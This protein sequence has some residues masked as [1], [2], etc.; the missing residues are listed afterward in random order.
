MKTMKR[1]ATAI[2]LMMGL[3]SAFAQEVNTTAMLEMAP[4]RHQINPAWEPITDGYF[5]FPVLSHLKLY[6]GWNALTMSDVIFK[7]DGTTMWALNPNSKKDLM[8]AFK[9]NNLARFDVNTALLGF[10]FRLKNEGYL[11]INLDLHA[12]AGL[13]LPKG[14]FQ[15]VLGGGMTDLT[16]KNTFD[17][18]GLGMQGQAYV[19]LGVGYS[20]Q[21]TDEWT[22]GLKV[23]AIEGVAYAGMRNKDLKLEAS[24]EQWAIAG[25]GKLRV[26]APLSTFPTSLNPDSLKDWMDNGEKFPSDLKQIIKTV[27]TPSGVGLG[28]DLGATY[29][30]HEM[31]KISFA[32][33]DV[34]AIYW[35]RGR[36]YN[37]AVNMM[38][39][40]IGEFNA[41]DYMDSEG[42]F[43]TNA[44]SDTVMNRLQ[45]IYMHGFS[46]DNALKKGFFT[47]LTGK[48]NVGV[49]GYFCN[50]I[51]GV[52][53]YSSTMLYNSKLYEELTLG[54]A[55]RPCTWFNFGVS[56]SMINGKWGNLGAALGLRGGPIAFT[57]AMDYVP[58]SWAKL[59]MDEKTIPLPYKTAGVN[60]GMGLNIV[61]GWKKRDKDKDG[62]MDKFDLCPKTPKGVA[63]DEFGCPI[64]SDGD[65]VPDYLD[66]CPGTPLAAYGLIDEKGCAIDSDG[67]GVPDYLDECP[68]TGSEVWGYVDE[69]GCALDSDGDG[70]EDYRDQCPNTPAGAA[71][72]VDANGCELDSDGDGV[73][74]WLDECPNTPAEALSAMDEKGC[75]VDTDGDGVPDYLD[76][77]PNTPAEAAGHVDAKGCELDT[78]GDGVPDYLDMCPEIAGAKDNKGCPAMKKETTSILKKAMQG[79]QFE[80]GKAVIKKASYGILDKVAD[81]FLEN[82][83]Y[84]AEVQGHTDNVGKPELNKKL[85]QARAESVRDYLIKKGV[86]AGRLTAMGYGD[87]KPIASN[88]TAAGRT[89]NRRVEFDIEYKIVTV[90]EIKQ[91]ADP[92]S[93]AADETDSSAAVVT[94]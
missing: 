56:Y 58:V 19:Q 3:S 48:L 82:P 57:F 12:D 50:N 13:G 42:N 91:F 61:W 37:Y 32:L 75:P 89:Q 36:Q 51:I 44:V 17:L 71:G 69:K 41:K 49:D 60:M 78:D 88:K 20:K 66:E 55:L 80:T 54:A 15:F 73:P 1:F 46:S 22:W 26:A 85:S 53:L 40:G 74:D 33:T 9:R 68:G 43:D 14:L 77:C 67:D 18:S 27:L 76:E 92:E 94:E 2:L 64:D 4:Y 24:P 81:V 23:K 5:Y 6:G 11:H 86:E 38:Y 65:G 52:G 7:Q 63:V 25:S 47:P 31:V 34:G 39:D 84:Y 29:Q 90:E 35:M 79:I 28:F 10:G 62:V 8:D 59:P 72:Y 93:G 70:V 83:T 21:Q 87:E 30:P 16:G 45:D